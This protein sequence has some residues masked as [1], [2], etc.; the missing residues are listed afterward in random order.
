[1]LFVSIFTAK[2]GLSTEQT[3]ETLPRWL[4][5]SP[6]EGIKI[7]AEYWLQTVPAQVV[8]ISEAENPAPIFL[9]NTAWGDVFDIEVHPA[10][11]AEEGLKLAEQ[12]LEQQAAQ[13]PSELQR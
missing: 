8:G 6:P 7:L 3:Q 11:R 9:A 12:A 4:Q 1:M 5:W 10:L 13:V 2:S